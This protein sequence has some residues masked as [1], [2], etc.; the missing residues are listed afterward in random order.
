MIIYYLII[1]IIISII[2]RVFGPRVGSSLQARESR[3]QFYQRQ[4]FH[5][6]LRNKVYS[7]TWD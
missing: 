5:R 2:I 6:T 4:V 7:F 3:L 1:I